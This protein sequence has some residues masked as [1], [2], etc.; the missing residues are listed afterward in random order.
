[1]LRQNLV[2][3]QFNFRNQVLNFKTKFGALDFFN[4]IRRKRTNPTIRLPLGGLKA[5][6]FFIRITYERVAI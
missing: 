6:P 3:Q 5:P 4:S 1:M 2:L